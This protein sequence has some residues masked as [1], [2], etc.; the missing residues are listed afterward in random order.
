MPEK[1]SIITRYNLIDQIVGIVC[2][3]E[4]TN[5]GHLTGICTRIE[6]FFCRL[7]IYDLVLKHVCVLLFGKSIGTTFDFGYTVLKNAWE[8]LVLPEFAPYDIDEFQ[9]DVA[10]YFVQNATIMQN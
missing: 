10:V 2:D 4:A 5:I 6:N 3:T 1:L 7:H 9:G 8:S